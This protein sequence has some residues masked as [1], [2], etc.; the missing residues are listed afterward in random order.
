MNL[1][2]NFTLTELCK[3]QVRGVDNTAPAEVISRLRVLCERVLQPTRDHF[4]PVVVNSGY[5][6]PAVN[7][8]VGGSKTS[9]HMRGE[10]ADIECPGIHN[11]FLAEWISENLDFD[12]VILECYEPGGDPNSG[13]VHVSYSAGRNRREVLTFDGKRYMRGLVL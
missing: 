12:Q 10:A 2:K 11:Y 4:G 7:A 8:A 9:Q 5:R 6:S 3:T 1:S 13:W